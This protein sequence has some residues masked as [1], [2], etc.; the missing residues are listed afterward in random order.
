MTYSGLKKNCEQY[1]KHY[2]WGQKRRS[3]LRG[4]VVL[5]GSAVK[6]GDIYHL[7]SRAFGQGVSIS[8]VV[9]FDI[10]DVVTVCN[11]YVA[12]DFADALAGR[13]FRRS[14]S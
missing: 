13:R 12:I 2:D 4:V 11:V 3:G 7:L 8:E 14:G 10:F 1:G 5:R 6:R 9:D